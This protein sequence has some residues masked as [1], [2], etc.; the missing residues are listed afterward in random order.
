M[1]YKWKYF[2][3]KPVCYVFVVSVLKKG[4]WWN[5]KY[6]NN[7]QQITEGLVD[8]YEIIIDENGMG[9]IVPEKGKTM[10]G[11]LWKVTEEEC[12]DIRYFYGEKECERREIKMKGENGIEYDKVR[13]YVRIEGK[14]EKDEIIQEYTIETQKNKYN[15]VGHKIKIE[16]TY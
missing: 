11:E 9:W 1:W 12:E 7:G 15:P 4:F 8:D 13:I 16:E 6:L 5:S 10:K 2:T 14:T 3:S